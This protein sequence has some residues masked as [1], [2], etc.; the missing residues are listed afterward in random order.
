[1]KK[2]YLSALVLLALLVRPVAADENLAG[3]KKVFAEKQDSVVW[4]SGV[5][6]ISFTAADSKDAAITPPDEETKVE[7]LATI[8]D[9]AGLAVAVL[10]QLDPA[11]GLNGRTVRTVHGP[12]KVDA[13]ATL[14]EVKLILAD[15][16]EVPADV[17]LK[18][19]DLDLAFI[20]IKPASKEAKGAS[21]PAV[22][23]QDSA[24][25]KIL[26]EVVTV[27]RL[28]EVF[29]RAPNVFPGYI[30]MITKKPRVF[31]RA[32]GATGGCPTFTHE[33]K[34]IGITAGRLVKGKPSAAAIIPAAEVLEVVKQI[35]PVKPTE[36]ERRGKV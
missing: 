8:V 7:S 34:I 6:T 12:V 18:D 24:P 21:F 15:G 14:K 35:K 16:T 2:T 17:V 4:I 32:T 26:D 9:P 30:N 23:L 25:G 13:V 33:G 27:T 1:M 11:R 36:A 22:D 3:A 5:A 20:R 28:D 31:L 29:N 19:V 10:S